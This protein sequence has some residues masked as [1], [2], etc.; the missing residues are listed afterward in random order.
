MR[1]ERYFRVLDKFIIYGERVSVRYYIKEVPRP[2][3]PLLRLFAR[4]DHFV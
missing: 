1:K 2:R 3:S 4:M